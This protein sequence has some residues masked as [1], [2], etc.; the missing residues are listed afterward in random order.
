MNSCLF[1]CSTE[2]RRATI[3]LFALAS[4]AI[5]VRLAAVF[6]VAS[7]RLERVTYEHG[8]IARNIVE[9]RGFTV[10]WLGAEGPTSQQAPAYPSLVAAFYWLFGVETP[11]AL[12]ALQ[13]LQAALGGPLAVIVSLLSTELL[14]D[15][16]RVA[17]LAGIA[18]A[19]YPTLV[20]AA[21]QV[22]VAS[23]AT[24]LVVAV[25]WL[26]ARTARTHSA[27]A[28]IV[29]GFVSGLL[30]LTDP[31][32]AIVVI[33]ALLMLVWPRVSDR[34]PLITR[35]SRLTG[36]RPATTVHRSPITGAALM[37][38]VCAAVVAP[39]IVRNFLVHGE[40][41]FV[42]STFGY[43][44]WQGNHARSF[45]TDKIPAAGLDA[46]ESPAARTPSELER[47][48]WQA[49]HGATFYIDDVV[50]TRERV[51]ELGRLT[52]PQLSQ[53]LLAES[54][55]YIREHPWHYVRLCGQRLQFFLLFDETNPK[56]RVLAYRL[57]HVALLAVSVLGLWLSR[58]DARRLWP[59]YLAFALVTMFH[60]LTIV[61]ARFHIPLEPIQIVWA[62]CALD[63]VAHH[64]VAATRRHIASPHGLFRQSPV[65]PLASP[66]ERV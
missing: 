17:W 34:S 63:A 14:P 28:N 60:S 10:R 52:E 42:K 50:L 46:N 20:Y 22:Q 61:S 29:C 43:A 23:L 13:L 6:A 40:L 16:R 54:L 31:I 38:T 24:L 12:F 41:V 62:A 47:Q 32:L 8:E 57:S 51:A 25:L 2:R 66:A 65:S 48:L 44:F 4:L 56:S 21:T 18:A 35:H 30:I 5:V 1:D 3:G 9:G 59:T 7:Y 33:V 39:W 49:R 55:A 53:R 11:A 19:T 45:G 27:R 37:L 26:A 15:R 58:R 36:H 64:A